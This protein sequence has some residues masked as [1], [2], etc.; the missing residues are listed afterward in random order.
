MITSLKERDFV[1]NIHQF[2]LMGLP[3]ARPSVSCQH[4]FSLYQQNWKIQGEIASQQL[5]ITAFLTLIP[6]TSFP[7]YRP[8]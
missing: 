5:V 6:P 1:V 7:W 8:K 3:E 4:F 2:S